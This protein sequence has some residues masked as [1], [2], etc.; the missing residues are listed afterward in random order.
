[1][2]DILVDMDTEIDALEEKIYKMKL[3]KSVMMSEPLTGRIRLL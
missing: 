2:T 3:M 1:M